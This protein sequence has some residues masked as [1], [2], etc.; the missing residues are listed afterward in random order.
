MDLA[1]VQRHD[2]E[3]LQYLRPRHAGPTAVNLPD[4]LQNRSLAFE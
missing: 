1:R 4:A 2:E 3:P